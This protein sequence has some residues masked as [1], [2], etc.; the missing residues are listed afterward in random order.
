MEVFIFSTCVQVRV[1]RIIFDV[2]GLQALYFN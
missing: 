1:L 2:P